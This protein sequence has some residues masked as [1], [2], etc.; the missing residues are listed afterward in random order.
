LLPSVG[1]A[2]RSQPRVFPSSK[3]G[4]EIGSIGIAQ[5]AKDLSEVV[6][7]FDRRAAMWSDEA[8]RRDL[9]RT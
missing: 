6:E 9:V 8:S 7:E 5:A 3:D 1:M 4:P 2:K